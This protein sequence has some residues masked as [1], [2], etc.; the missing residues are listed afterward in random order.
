MRKKDISGKPWEVV[1]WENEMYGMYKIG[2]WESEGNYD[3]YGK[4][5]LGI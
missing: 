4:R 5:K 2:V 3:V 1:E